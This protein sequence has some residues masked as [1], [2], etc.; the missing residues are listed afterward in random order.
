[1]IIQNCV[2][3]Q[4]FGDDESNLYEKRLTMRQFRLTLAFFWCILFRFPR[5]P[6][7]TLGQ[8]RLRT[9]MSPIISSQSDFA[10]APRAHRSLSLSMAA[11]N[12]A[13][14]HRLEEVSN[15]DDYPKVPL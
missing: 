3:S 5:C 12:H 6:T 7:E 15:F 10:L 8:V 1:M 2:E 4:I 13:A 9:A 14:H 11:D